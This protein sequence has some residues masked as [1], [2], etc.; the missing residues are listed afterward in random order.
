MTERRWDLNPQPGTE[1]LLRGVSGAGAHHSVNPTPVVQ[2]CLVLS[3]R[4][5]ETGKINTESL[6]EGLHKRWWAVLSEMLREIHEENF[7]EFGIL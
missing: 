5:T 3:R 7:P 2:C 6:S 1:Y 4:V